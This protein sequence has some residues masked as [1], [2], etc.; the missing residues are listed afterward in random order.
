M[1][2]NIGILDPLGKNPN[3]L[4]N[5]PYSDKYRELAKYWTKFPIYSQANEI[6]KTIQDNQ[7]IMIVSGTGSGKTVLVPKYA[8][9]VLKY[10]GKIVVVLPKQVITKK[11][12]DFAK[13][14]LDV[15][16]NQIGYQYRGAP[17]N[18]SS[19][20]TQLLY[21][22][23]GTIVNKVM[24]DPFLSEYD[25]VILD[26]VHERQ[27]QIDLL[28]YLLRKTLSL[29]PEFKLILM[30]ATID[31]TLFKNYF[32]KET[33]G[34]I[35]TPGVKNYPVESIFLDK[36]INKNDYLE[37]AIS[38]IKEID[39][40]NDK[41]IAPDVI[42]FVPSVSDCIKMCKLLYKHK[43]QDFCIEAY[44]G[45]SDEKV[46]IVQNADKYKTLTP[47]SDKYLRKVIVATNFAE[48]SLTVSGLGYVIDSGYEIF[49]YY[50]P[51]TDAKVIEKQYTSKAS[52]MQR[53]GR[54][55]RLSPGICYHLYTEDMFENKFEKYNPAQIRTSDITSDCLKFMN[56]DAILTVE[57]L[58]KLLMSF[59]EPPKPKYI[60]AAIDKLELLDLVKDKQITDFGKIIADT[61]LEPMYAISIYCGKS[62]NCS[63]EVISIL[64][65]IDAMSGK[66][67]NLFREPVQMDD[68]KK[69]EL[70]KKYEKAR[71][72]LMSNLGDHIAIYNIFRKYI[73]LRKDHKKLDNWLFKNFINTSVLVKAYMYYNKIKNSMN[74]EVEV[75]NDVLKDYTINEC[76]LISL[77]YGF[78]INVA[79]RD[80]E[81]Y[82]TRK[83]DGALMNK[84][85]LMSKKADKVFYHELMTTE[86][87]NEINIVSGL[88]D[89]IMKAIKSINIR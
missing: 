63:R 78:R 71:K 79:K 16:T 84:N 49:S 72:D 11:A 40:S 4:N 1:E 65:M 50:D 37:K 2:N 46:E 54:V 88:S 51:S 43:L 6:I 66:I 36:S 61:G 83:L 33:F 22:T 28:L 64:S 39:K 80:G 32:D 5:Q 10:T 45:I 76:I 77:G 19:K 14:T 27:V 59:I 3:P 82:D 34:V 23:N 20:N 89:K 48:S 60:N 21:A 62:L 55:G 69:S 53:K 42:F 70:T 44:A 81:S 29:R 68:N 26:E 86:N 15:H 87:K 7:V 25:C 41:E 38:I 9:H 13:D 57:N 18:A 85:S 75:N 31:I 24:N 52:I 56:D 73:Q 12:A 8:L 58:V 67:D 35:N 17:S 74:M 47:D 30:S